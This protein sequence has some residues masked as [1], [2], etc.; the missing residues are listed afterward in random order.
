MDLEIVNRLYLEL[1]QFATATTRRELIYEAALRAIRDEPHNPDGTTAMKQSLI[2]KE[3][4]F[5][6]KRNA[7]P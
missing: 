2:A 4:L 5:E 1:S 7:Q 3:A 6:A